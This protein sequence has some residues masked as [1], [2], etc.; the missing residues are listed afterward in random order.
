MLW[1]AFKL[2]ENIHLWNTFIVLG[3]VVDTGPAGM[4][5]GF[6]TCV[7]HLRGNWGS[8]G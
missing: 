6:H 1:V 4:R 2:L 3:P 5:V 7:L 8:R